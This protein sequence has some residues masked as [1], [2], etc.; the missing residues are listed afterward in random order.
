[1]V[2]DPDR[3]AEVVEDLADVVRVDAVDDV[4]SLA[5]YLDSVADYLTF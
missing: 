2:A 4:V 3:D 5:D 1:M